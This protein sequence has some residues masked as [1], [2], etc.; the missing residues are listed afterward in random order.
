[1][2]GHSAFIKLLVITQKRRPLVHF[3]PIAEE[4]QLYN[5][6][7]YESQGQYH[8]ELILTRI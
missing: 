7:K 3:Y 5:S 4:D 6:S 2:K 1:M 8:I